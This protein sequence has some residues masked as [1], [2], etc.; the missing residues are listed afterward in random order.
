LKPSI[1]AI[2]SLFFS[3]PEKGWAATI[4]R[5]NGKNNGAVL[6]ETGDGGQSWERVSSLG[7]LMSGLLDLRFSED[8]KWWAV[9]ARN[10]TQGGIV[11]SSDRGKTWRVQTNRY[12]GVIR[13][14]KT[15]DD[16][17][18]WAVGD[19]TISST[20]NGGQTWN[21]LYR[22]RLKSLNDLDVNGPNRVVVVGESGLILRSEDGGK[23]WQ[24]SV[25]PAPNTD[26]FLGAVRFVDDHRGWAAGHKGRV[27]F[28]NDGG[29]TWTLETEIN[30]YFIRD[31]AITS[32]KIIVVGNDAAIFWRALPK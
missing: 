10:L 12:P 20:E 2:D 23:T 7:Q 30:S 11:E 4:D 21:I 32:D 6:L 5:S 31:I 27:F 14:L 3:T 9:G 28:T 15:L 16:S 24:R 22:D 29:S 13:R 17:H 8:G 25:L 26:T 1:E 19:G 18:G